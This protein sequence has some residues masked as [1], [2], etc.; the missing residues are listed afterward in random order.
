MP[1]GRALLTFSCKASLLSMADAWRKLVFDKV[2]VEA[3]CALRDC[4][5]Y[6]KFEC[7]QSM[8][9]VRADKATGNGAWLWWEIARRACFLGT[10]RRGFAVVVASFTSA[11]PS[12]HTCSCAKHREIHEHQTSNIRDRELGVFSIA[13]EPV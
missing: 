5:S 12:P 1:Y 13:T 9:H 2:V 6:S 10:Y 11:A 3:L 7:Q 8:H 4:L